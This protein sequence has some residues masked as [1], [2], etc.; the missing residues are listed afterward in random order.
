MSLD[1]GQLLKLLDIDV[2]KP[3]QFTSL[4]QICIMPPGI[5]LTHLL[6]ADYMIPLIRD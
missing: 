3:T 5:L 2:L 1:A 4:L 6:G